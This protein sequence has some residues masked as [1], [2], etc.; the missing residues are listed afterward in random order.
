[1][2]TIWRALA[3]LGT[4]ASLIAV[5]SACVGTASAEKRECNA[6]VS[7]ISFGSVHGEVAPCG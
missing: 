1:M 7:L 4:V 3:L 6:D 2:K 5:G